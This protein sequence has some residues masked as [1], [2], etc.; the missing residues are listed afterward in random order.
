M[1][2]EETLAGFPIKQVVPILVSIFKYFH[3]IVS[4]D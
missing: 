1:G 3:S 4:K 2:N